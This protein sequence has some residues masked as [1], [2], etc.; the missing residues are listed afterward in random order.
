MKRHFYYVSLP[1]LI[2]RL[3]AEGRRIGP[4]AALLGT[5]ETGQTLSL[6]LYNDISNILI[7][8]RAGA[9]KSELLR[10][11]LFSLVSHSLPREVSIVIS[12]Y[13][14]SIYRDNEELIGPLFPFGH[15]RHCLR[16]IAYSFEKAMALLSFVI[17]TIT[18]RQDV[19]FVRPLIVPVFQ[20]VEQLF[21]RGGGPFMERLIFALQNGP[22]VG[23]HSI[24]TGSSVLSSQLQQ[25]V[26]MADFSVRIVGRFDSKVEARAA[27]GVP[28]VPAHRLP[29]CDFFAIRGGRALRFKAAAINDYELYLNIERL[30]K[31]DRGRGRILP[32][33]SYAPAS[34][35]AVAEVVR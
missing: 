32:R 13:A 16:P 23:V 11:M 26:L 5:A 27:A 19:G 18:E 22:A 33:N 28:D 21:Y 34:Y 1:N 24:V 4:G 17:D 20:N 30:G 35:A 10:A 6:N 31:V 14:I 3:Q 2:G 9:G 7:L 12:D 8:G 25:S 29:A 15:A